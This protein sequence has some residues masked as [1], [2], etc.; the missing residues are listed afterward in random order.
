MNEIQYLTG[1]ETSATPERN[2]TPNLYKNVS[3]III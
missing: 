1:F 3:E 2:T